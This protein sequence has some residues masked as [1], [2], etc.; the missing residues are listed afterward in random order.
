LGFD[1]LSGGSGGIL[2]SAFFSGLLIIIPFED[3]K[4]A[5]GGWSVSN[6]LGK[7]AYAS[8]Y[9]ADLPHSLVS[10]KGLGRGVLD[11]S[12]LAKDRISVACKLLESDS[13][14]REKEEA[15]Q[16]RKQKKLA[17]RDG[18]D[19]V[20]DV[21]AKVKREM[22][23]QEQQLMA[24]LEVMT[25]Y[26]HPN[27]CMLLGFGSTPGSVTSKPRRCFVYELCAHGC[28]FSILANQGKK[29]ALVLT[30]EHRLT[31][32]M[33]IGRGINYLHNDA[34]PP[35]IHRGKWNVKFVDD[36]TFIIRRCQIC[37]YFN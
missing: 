17:K 32:A 37:E 24:E 29:K 22:D 9:R 23:L 13:E 1:S 20:A 3:L 14:V 6:L 15:R 34:T 2:A 27:L 8:V 12:L 11:P 16:R 35:V 5:A 21:A 4:H 33:D 19:R 36:L 30:P 26:R 7:G 25:R 18:E 10:E 31:I 28:L